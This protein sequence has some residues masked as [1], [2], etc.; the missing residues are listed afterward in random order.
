MISIIIPTY[1]SAKT[2]KRCLDSIVAQTYEDYEILVMD[3]VSKDDTVL[4]TQSYNNPRIRVC[5]EPDNGIYDAMNKG[6]LKSKGEWLY[7][8]GSDD[9]LYAPDVLENVSSELNPKYKI[10]YGDVDTTCLIPE[11]MGEWKIEMIDYNRCHQAIFY[12]RSLFN[13]YGLYDTTY[14]LYAD[15]MYNIRCFWEYKVP[16]KYSNIA[17]AHYSE[18]GASSTCDDTQFYKDY[19]IIKFRY[20]RKGRSIN[21]RKELAWEVIRNTDSQW[22][23]FKM[24]VYVYYLRFVAKLQ[25]LSPR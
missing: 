2:I 16:T 25:S 17:I 23:K 1:N 9:Y 7:F 19:N 11:N 8:L 3:G 22:L 5:S 12:H 6:I 15:Y 14:R 18:G 24:R 4:L 10:V 13:K 21:Q 20:N